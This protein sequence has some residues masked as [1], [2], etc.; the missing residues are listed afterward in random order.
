MGFNGDLY[1]TG[2]ASVVMTTKGDIARYNTARE[3]LGIGS[4]NQI[5]QV[6]SA[7]PSWET[8][9]LADTVLTTA[10]DVLYENAT[11]EL[12]RLSAG[13]QYHNLQMGSALPAWSASS[14]STLTTTGD[15]LYA[16][17]A[18]T[19]A[20]LASVSSGQVLT[21]QGVGSAPAWALAGGGGATEFVGE[22]AQTGTTDQSYSTGAITSI[23]LTAYD[24]LG[25]ITCNSVTTPARINLKVNNTTDFKFCSCFINNAGSFSAIYTTNSVGAPVSGELNV[26]AAGHFS[27]QFCLMD[28]Q[29]TVRSPLFYQAWGFSNNVNIFGVAWLDGVLD[30][31]TEMEVLHTDGTSGVNYLQ[32]CTITLWKRAKS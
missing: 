12:A 31:F 3:R 14:T 8:V 18:N 20:R 30:T 26:P 21:S 10:G 19:L 17:G 1:A 2:G 27:M 15:L 13:T 32:N 28:G 24:I 25:T 29:N 6:K 16:S 9:P 22:F 11:P 7:L 4:T 23:D 5:L